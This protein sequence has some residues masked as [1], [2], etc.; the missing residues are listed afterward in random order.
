M[1]DPARTAG[2]KEP[3]GAARLA[4]ADR[5]DAAIDPALARCRATTYESFLNCPDEAFA[6]AMRTLEA[7]RK[8]FGDR[9]APLR[10]WARAQVAVFENCH[11]GSL[12]LPIAAPAG[13]DD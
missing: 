10:D 4:G 1:D 2:S 5:A 12:V 3:R 7:R 11:D 8:R 13:A 9:S 6:G